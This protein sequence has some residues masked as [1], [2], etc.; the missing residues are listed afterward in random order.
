MERPSRNSQKN[1]ANNRIKKI[2][3]DF[4][5]YSIKSINEMPQLNAEPMYDIT[6]EN[7]LKINELIDTPFA[8]FDGIEK[9][10]TLEEK[11]AVIFCATIRGHKFG[12]GNK[13]TAVTLLLAILYVNEKWTTITWTT[14]YSL[15]MK[16]ASNN[17]MSFDEQIEEI[18][19]EITPSIINLPQ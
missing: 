16:I 8:S 3:L 1:N 17:S 6:D 4:A 7:I 9:Y 18:S 13:R 15:A 19:K 10:Q 11:A 12:N 5:V 2:P 14:L